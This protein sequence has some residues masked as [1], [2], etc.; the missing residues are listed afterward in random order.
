MIDEY[1]QDSSSLLPCKLSAMSKTYH[2]L[3]R[4]TLTSIYLLKTHIS[5]QANKHVSTLQTMIMVAWQD[6]TGSLELDMDV[7]HNHALTAFMGCETC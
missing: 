4:H 2:L 7:N 1:I 3:K 5:S 6:V